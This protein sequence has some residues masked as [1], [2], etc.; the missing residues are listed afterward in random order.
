MKRSGVALPAL[1]V[2][3]FVVLVLNPVTFLRRSEYRGE[4]RTLYESLQPGM[5]RRQVRAA[6]DSGR[7]P[8]LRF[9][10]DDD[11]RWVAF[12]PLE[13]G[14]KN[15]VLLIEFEGERVSGLRVRTEDSLQYHPAEAPR[16]KERPRARAGQPHGSETVP[17]LCPRRTRDAQNFSQ[18]H[19]SSPGRQIIGSTIISYP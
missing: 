4:V 10:T 6:I 9:H 16:N 5:G 12:A 13:F 17:E 2:G 15:W 11:Y 19:T 8:H 1:I 3:V 18:R 7:F 14:A